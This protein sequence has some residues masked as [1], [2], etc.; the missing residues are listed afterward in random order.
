MSIQ[1]PIVAVCLCAVS[2]AA[3]PAL[4]GETSRPDNSWFVLGEKVDI[5]L[6]A[7]GLA[8]GER[9]PLDIG[10]FD[11]EEKELARIGAE[12]VADGDG[13][14]R[15]SFEMPAD[16]YG[17]YRVRP[18]LGGPGAITLP[19]RG[20]RPAGCLT[21]AVLPDFK[22]LPQPDEDDAFLGLHGGGWDMAESMGAHYV[23][24]YP[25]LVSDDGRYDEE[26]RRRIAEERPWARYGYFLA[27][28]VTKRNQFEF[29]TDEGR[30][31]MAEQLKDM[32]PGSDGKPRRMMT[33][34]E[35]CATEE[36]RRHYGDALRTFARRAR[37]RDYGF[38]RR[39]YEIF[40]EPELEAPSHEAIVQVAQTA[41]EAIHAED[42]DALCAVPTFY[43]IQRTSLPL[44]R[45][46]LEL[47]LGKYMDAFSVHPYGYPPESSGVKENVRATRAL[48]R[49]FTGRDV[50]FIGTESGANVK[51]NAAEECAARDGFVRANLI[52][53]GEGFLFNTPFYGADFG[54]DGQSRTDGD[55]GLNYNLELPKVKFGPK[56]TSPRP[57]F[58]AFAAMAML[59]DGKRPTACLESLGDTALGYAYQGRDGKC[60]VALWDAGEAPVEA[61][62]PVG[63]ETVE[64]ADVMG[65]RRTASAPG[66]ELTLRLSASP[67]YVVDPD[68]GLWGKDG[69]AV[70]RLAEEAARRRAAD[71]AMHPLS[72]AGV[73]PAW[74]DGGP[75]VAV[76][77]ENRSTNAVGGVLSTRIP[78]V[79]EARKQTKVAFGA[80]E[81]KTVGVPFEGFDPDPFRRYRVEVAVMPERPSAEAASAEANL[82]FLFARR[83]PDGASLA[84]WPT[85]A[86]APFPEGAVRLPGRHGGPVDC[87]AAIGMG[88]NET[89]LL[90][91]FAVDDDSF[92]QNRTGWRTWDS[93]CIQ[94]G[95]AKNAAPDA[96]GGNGWAELQETAYSEID[97][98]LTPAGPEAYRTVTFDASRFPTDMK[99]AGRIDPAD[100]PLHI[101]R[102]NC[103]TGVRLRY[104]TVIP[105]AFFNKSNA[106]SGET[107]WFAAQIN[108]RD[109]PAEDYAHDMPSIGVFELKTAAPA[110][111]GPVTLIDGAND[112]N[113][114]PTPAPSLGFDGVLGCAPDGTN[115]FFRGVTALALANGRVVAF[116]K[117]GRHS[118]YEV[119]W[120]DG[121]PGDPPLRVIPG[122]NNY[123]GMEK[124]PATGKRSIAQGAVEVAES[125]DGKKVLFAFRGEVGGRVLDL[126]KNEWIHHERGERQYRTERRPAG[127]PKEV[128]LVGGFRAAVVPDGIVLLDPDGSEVQTIPCRATLLASEGRWL[129]AYV[130]EKACFHRYRL[131]AECR[132]RTEVSISSRPTGFS[133]APA[134]SKTPV[135][136]C[137]MAHLHARTHNEFRP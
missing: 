31:W 72:V 46:C 61:R 43:N 50:P 40:W 96:A 107:V 48:V 137:R 110:N 126:S 47:G 136:A 128:P 86:I 78:G 124:D 53:L 84:D 23:L 15:G 12:V 38:R 6:A 57:M 135:A 58:P 97:L 22:A 102:E 81:T 93:D 32:K 118:R 60:V 85:L 64:V 99:G 56:R 79:P 24:G 133:P 98:A 44:L 10:V 11:E 35:L 106:A 75:G 21:Y 132:A 8:P 94:L 73:R 120:L 131:G 92:V 116:R 51:A 7:E 90:L 52:L 108:D 114:P 123:A 122:E 14:W 113:V 65:N 63:R 70:A 26:R 105:W 91:E 130:P 68:P 109:D 9:L 127:N 41:W 121:L 80:N 76:R 54:D 33:Q 104:R 36:G 3:A 74:T 100:M 115:G 5:S 4:T 89:G 129:V 71:E 2:A 17:F 111:F 27:N 117:Y 55:Y 103:A 39:I 16:H 67:Q 1:F 88:W 19:Q 77:I 101:D 25:N 34:F 13:V 119:F 49:E 42:P 20:S 82:G 62:I 66:G 45:H 30:A 37:S 83:V 87:S 112:G 95:L 134:F 69:T 29:F 59:V 28:N 18:V 125:I